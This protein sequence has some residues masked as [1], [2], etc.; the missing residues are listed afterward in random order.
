MWPVMHAGE[1]AALTYAYGQLHAKTRAEVA[2]IEARTSAEIAEIRRQA[3]AEVG[4]LRARTVAAESLA[5]RMETE[6]EEARTALQSGAKWPRSQACMHARPNSHLHLITLRPPSD[7]PQGMADTLRLGTPMAALHYGTT[8]TWHTLIGTPVAALIGCTHARER[9]IR[10]MSR[11]LER[12]GCIS[13]ASHCTYMCMIMCAPRP[14]PLRNLA[15]THTPT[16]A[17]PSACAH[18]VPMWVAYVAGPCDPAPTARERPLPSASERQ[19]G[20][21]LSVT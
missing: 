5:E 16:K 3:E 2:E 12:R 18:V 19:A 9:A 20:A 15:H 8:H 6:Y 11:R 21:S 17:A 14:H 13:L 10:T 1:M 7:H 4:E